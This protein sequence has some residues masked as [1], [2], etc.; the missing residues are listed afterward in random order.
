MKMRLFAQ[1]LW[2]WVKKNQ[3][4]VIYFT[5]AVLIEMTAVFTVEGNPFFTRP[6]IFLGFI[7]AI[8]GLVSLIPNNRV[9][10]VIFTVLLVLQGVLD[11]VFAVIFDMTGQ[12][13]DFGMLNLRNDAFGTLESIPVNFGTFYAAVLFCALYLIYGL[14][15]TY[16]D[17]SVKVH[18]H[19]AFFY[20][21]AA[22]AGVATCGISLAAYYPRNGVD[23]YDEMINGKAGSAYSAYGMIGNLIGEFSGALFEDD[24]ELS[25][26][27]I[28][29]FIYANQSMPTEY[30]GTSKDKNVLVIL[31]ETLEWYS[32]LVNDEHPN[33][34]G[35]TN[36]ELKELYPNLNRFYDEGL[37]MTNFHSREKTDIAETLSIMGSY[38]TDAYINYD[39]SENTMPTT[40]PNILAQLYGREDISLR[41]FHNGFK[42]F[43][44]RVEAHAAFGFEGMTDMDDMEQMAQDALDAGLTDKLTFHDTMKDGERNLDSEMVETAKDLMFPTDK[45][46]YSYITTI[47]MHGV[48]YPRNNLQ[49]AREKLKEALGER[50]PTEEETEANVLFEYMSTALEF[51][52]AIGGVF[53]DLEKK[54]L[55]D[56]TVIVLFGDHN[57]YYQDLSNYVKDIQDYD[58]D[59][60]RKFTDLYNVP[61][62]I[63]DTDLAAKIAENKDSRF[64]DKFTCTADIVPTLLDLL[65]IRYYTNLYYGH[66]VF[67]DAQSVLYSR[68]YDTFISDGLVGKSV[69]KLIYR[70]EGVSQ[71]AIDAYRAEGVR[72]VEK[73]KYCDYIFRQD[74]FAEGE[75]LTQYQE[76]MRKLNAWKKG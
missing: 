51:D 12:Y 31:G 33:A 1:K 23:K 39:Y 76:S 18:R 29:E 15:I 58:D 37:V 14:R 66:S 26:S 56:D 47:T 67:D 13:F 64:I 34:L 62:M 54:G 6:F 8:C 49:W 4:T 20:A 16:E 24:T 63:Y 5:F 9:R 65:G 42:T 57:A 7:L 59:N 19:S 25:D 28:E 73:I 61:L 27:Q 69:N 32:F 68:A 75:N 17:S 2:E 74:Y 52:K 3:L 48:Y 21:M 45:P 10:L 50:M 35:L 40:V 30:F 11:L 46:F 41:S 53:A 44:N 43:Y 55:L 36:E 22:V 38:P 60:G 72:L 70:H 71:A